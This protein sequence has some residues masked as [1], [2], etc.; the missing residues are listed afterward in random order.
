MDYSHQ[1]SSNQ[2]QSGSEAHQS[3]ENSLVLISLDLLGRESVTL[4][5][6]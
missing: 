6:S 1:Y 2:M 3:L 5:I 4:F